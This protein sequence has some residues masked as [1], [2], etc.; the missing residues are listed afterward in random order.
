MYHDD[1]LKYVQ[2]SLDSRF[3]L[4]LDFWK[5]P[6]RTFKVCQIL[7]RFGAQNIWDLLSKKSQLHNQI[8][9]ELQEMSVNS[10]HPTTRYTIGWFRVH[11]D[12]LNRLCFID[13]VQSDVMES[14]YEEKFH[15]EKKGKVS[16]EILKEIDDWMIHGFA[17]IQRWSHSIGYRTAIHSKESA[18]NFQRED[19]TPSDRKWNTYYQSLIKHYKLEIEQFE[20]YPDRIFVEK[21]YS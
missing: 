3:Q 8:I 7:F 18:H 6:Q 14:L 16:L 13:E 20:I 4:S 10:S 19:M 2:E 1:L 5:G 9:S 17:T 21:K 12:D 15:D 11:V